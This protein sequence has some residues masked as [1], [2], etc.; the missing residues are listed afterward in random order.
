MSSKKQSNLIYDKAHALFSLNVGER[1]TLKV[2]QHLH[3]NAH[4]CPRF[5]HPQSCSPGSGVNFPQKAALLG[6]LVLG[7]LAPHFQIA[8]RH[9]SGSRRATYRQQRTNNRICLKGAPGTQAF[10]TRICPADSALHMPPFPRAGVP[11]LQDLMPD[12][13]RWSWSNNIRN[14]VHNKCNAPESSW[15]HPRKTVFHESGPCCQKGWGPWP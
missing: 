4:G 10:L 13:L 2:C 7:Q 14:K 3:K 9:V 8:L 15:N 6:C 1:W 12:D 11:N 5:P